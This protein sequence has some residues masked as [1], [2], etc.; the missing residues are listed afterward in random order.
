VFDTR[1]SYEGSEEVHK[2]SPRPYGYPNQRVGDEI[3]RGTSVPFI[4]EGD[5]DC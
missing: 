5:P 4:E 1:W 2:R 3:T